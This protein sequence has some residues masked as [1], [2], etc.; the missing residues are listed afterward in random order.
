M[1]TENNTSGYLLKSSAAVFITILAVLQLIGGIVS[2]WVYFQFTSADMI[3]KAAFPH[4]MQFLG[5][6]TS[7]TLATS[8]GILI[9]LYGL[10]RRIRK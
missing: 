10:G 2:A 8:I 7:A 6:I 5:G 1:K 3:G 9:G 4:F